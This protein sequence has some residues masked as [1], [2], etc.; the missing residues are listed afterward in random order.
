MKKRQL[1]TRGRLKTDTV[2]AQMLFHVSPVDPGSLIVADCAA[3]AALRPGRLERLDKGCLLSGSQVFR[4]QGHFELQVLPLRL[5]ARQVVPMVFL[6]LTRFALT[7]CRVF[8]GDDL[9]LV[10]LG[11]RAWGDHIVVVFHPVEDLDDVFRAWILCV[12][13]VGFERQVN[14]TRFTQNKKIGSKVSRLR[15]VPWG[16][17][18]FAQMKGRFAIRPFQCAHVDVTARLL[19][20]AEEGQ[21][22][23]IFT[24]AFHLLD[25]LAVLLGDMLLP[26]LLIVRQLVAH[27][28]PDFGCITHVPALALG[29]GGHCVELAVPLFR[30]RAQ[31]HPEPL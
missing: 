8:Q 31:M 12:D 13:L 10:L 2:L 22:V 21:V 5:A 14:M 4:G 11:G 17:G 1:H 24:V 23:A 30:L 15:I 7:T 9:G 28:T 16:D 19:C 3:F 29:A 25:V 18:C 20:K 6:F 26:Q 27:G